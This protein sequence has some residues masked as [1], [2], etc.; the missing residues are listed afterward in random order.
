[1]NLR[2]I[3]KICALLILLTFSNSCK[4]LTYYPISDGMKEYFVFQKGSYW[5]YKNDSTLSIDSTYIIAFSSKDN[6]EGY[7]GVKRELIS[8]LFK[9]KFLSDFE[10][11]YSCLGANTLAITSITDTTLPPD[12]YEAGGP[13][14]FFGNWL[15]NK[16]N[17]SN[18]CNTGGVNRY[19]NID[20]KEINNIIYRNIIYTRCITI[21][22]SIL[23]PNYYLR[24]IYF[25]K[26]IGIISFHEINPYFHIK[27]SYSIVRSKT[28]Q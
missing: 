17:I 2:N 10:L 5:I 20:S 28:I 7:P 12:S 14:A 19:Y 8:F 23:N 4:K 16:N 1:M 26:N 15:P 13:I 25:A 6:D 24:E 3:Y 22:S 9:S 27:R 18:A 21:D 11:G